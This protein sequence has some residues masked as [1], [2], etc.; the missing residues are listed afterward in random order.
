MKIGLIKWVCYWVICVCA[1]VLLGDSDQEEQEE[2][3]RACQEEREE[4]LRRAEEAHESVKDFIQFVKELK[5]GTCN[6]QHQRC[7]N[8]WPDFLEWIPGCG[9]QL[10]KCL[11]AAED[12][13]TEALLW[14]SVQ[15]DMEAGKMGHCERAY[16]ACVKGL[17]Y[18]RD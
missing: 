18:I 13:V 16:W 7:R 15:H 8:N 9:R 12:W 1:L 17:E 14:A 5:E 11:D 6:D 2:I 4:C 10:T 3:E